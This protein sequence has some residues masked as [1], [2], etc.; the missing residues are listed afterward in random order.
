MEIWLKLGA[1]AYRH[2]QTVTNDAG[3]YRV[4][5]IE[6]IR[7]KWPVR[8]ISVPGRGSVPEPWPHCVA[9]LPKFG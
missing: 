1:I 2:Y 5:E 6:G 4:V 9:E 3:D 7:F 8:R